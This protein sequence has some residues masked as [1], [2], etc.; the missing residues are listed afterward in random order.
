MIKFINALFTI[1]FFS[2]RIKRCRK[3]VS[4]IKSLKI[5]AANAFF[6]ITRPIDSTTFKILTGEIHATSGNA[7]ING[8]DINKSRFNARRNLG[9]CPQYDYLP[10]FLTVEETLMLFA[11]LRGLELKSIPET[12]KEMINIFKLNEFSAKYVQN[13]RLRLVFTLFLNKI[14][15]FFD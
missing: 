3:N 1:S 10:E 6:T 4:Q 15:Y 5:S 13:L 2:L 7:F 8:F 9:F 11:R 14:I 12:V